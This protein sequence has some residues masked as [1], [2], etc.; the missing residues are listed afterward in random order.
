MSNPL[1]KPSLQFM[2][3][4][5]WFRSDLVVWFIC[6]FAELTR[7]CLLLSKITAACWRVHPSVFP[8]ALCILAHLAASSPRLLFVSD[9]H[10][11][12]WIRPPPTLSCHPSPAHPSFPFLFGPLSSPPFPSAGS[13]I[14]ISRTHSSIH[15]WTDDYPV[16][17]HLQECVCFAGCSLNSTEPA[18]Q[19]GILGEGATEQKDGDWWSEKEKLSFTGLRRSKRQV[20]SYTSPDICAHVHTEM[21]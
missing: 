8:A 21:S 6:V 13:M 20:S 16:F 15:P 9:I 4:Q 7:S 17:S 3:S 5:T 19:T 1:L 12:S 11:P 18:G 14:L 10:P 2:T